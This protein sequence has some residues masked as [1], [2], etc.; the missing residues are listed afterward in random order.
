MNLENITK[1]TSYES[2]IEVCPG[3]ENHCTVKVFRFGNGK[4][5]YSGNQCERV[6]SSSAE[7]KSKGVN[8]FVE[9]NRLLWNRPLTPRLSPEVPR[10][11]IGIPRGLGIYEDFPFWATLLTECG[12]EVVLSRGSSNSL[13]EKGIRTIVADN[14]CFPAKLMHGHIMDLIGRKVDRILYPWVVFER[15]E[16]SASRN[17]FNCPIVSGY[18]DVINSSINPGKRYGIPLDAPVVSFKDAKLLRRSCAEYL[19][20]LGVSRKVAEKAV[21]KAAAEQSRYLDELERRSKEVLHNAV[22]EGRMVILLAARP[23]HIDPLIEHKISQAIADMGIDVIT[24]NVATHSG[25]D[26][27]SHINALCQWAYPNLHI[28]ELTSFGC[29][30]DAFILDEVRSILDRHGKNLTVLKIDDVNNIGSLKL[31]IRSLVDSVSIHDSQVT[32]HGSQVTLQNSEF[33]IYHKAFHA[34]GPSADTHRSLFC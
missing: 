27:Y 10:L 14:I 20:G 22:S 23:Y 17:S 7:S 5:F 32:G 29:G 13:Y 28:V 6:Y 1:G 31:R 3:C 8:M 34:R 11:R 4:S 12:F 24:E 19:A 15:K 2:G 26:V 18:S 33:K 30:P 25:A 16:D 21:E 9:K